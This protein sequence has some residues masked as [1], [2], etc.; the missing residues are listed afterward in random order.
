MTVSWG[1]LIFL[2][3]SFAPL[4]LGASLARA[5]ALL[6]WADITTAIAIDG[7]NTIHTMA[8]AQN[9]VYE[10]VNAITGRYP[11]DQVKLGPAQ[12]PG[13]PGA[14]G[15]SGAPGAPGASLDAAIAAAS[16]DVLAHEASAQ[17]TRIDA[18]YQKELG[19]LPDDPARAADRKSVV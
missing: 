16:H 5:D 10:A 18:V 9:A 1:R 3:S 12:G 17:A 7:P 14:K 4:L 6:D 13:A 15:A 19:K 8:L 11:K 2:G